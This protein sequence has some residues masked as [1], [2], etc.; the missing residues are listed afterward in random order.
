MTLLELPTELLDNIFSYLDWDRSRSLYPE[1][2]DLV[3]IS[4]T[5]RRLRKAL[6]PTIFRDVVL[7]LRWQEWRDGQLVEPCLY[8]LRKHCPELA[9]HVRCVYIR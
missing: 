7:R 8:K 6:S 3:N 1:R 9:A 5:C 2:E 4:L